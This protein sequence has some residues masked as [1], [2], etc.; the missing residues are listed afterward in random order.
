MKAVRESTLH[1]NLVRKQ[2]EVKT[3]RDLLSTWAAA[4][5][6][7]DDDDDD[8]WTRRICLAAS[9]WLS[10]SPSE[11]DERRR[12]CPGHITPV[13]MSLYSSTPLS[14]WSAHAPPFGRCWCLVFPSC[15]A[16]PDGVRPRATVTYRDGEH[17]LRRF[18]SLGWYFRAL[19]G[20]RINQGGP[21]RGVNPLG[22]L[23]LVLQYLDSGGAFWLS[24]NDFK[25]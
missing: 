21:G 16:R 8:R 15:I 22:T 24:P 3:R 20:D 9:S 5:D 19:D 13:G 2:A 1:D 23:R 14:D 18:R 10:C 7:A 6:V 11:R 4:A 17:V 25:L 12:T